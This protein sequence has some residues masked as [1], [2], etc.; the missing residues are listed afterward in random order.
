MKK[1]NWEDKLISG[2]NGN[3]VPPPPAAWDNIEAVL[4]NKDK[5][6]PLVFFLLMG[7]I[8]IGAGL[9]I[10]FN[11]F[12]S[13]KL[14]E[15]KINSNNTA[16]ADFDKKENGK[17]NEL[18]VN[19]STT[20]VGKL[21]IK[22]A[23]S[24]LNNNKKTA[25]LN[26]NNTLNYSENKPENK[27]QLKNKNQYTSAAKTI[28]N[29]TTQ[30]NSKSAVNN[31]QKTSNKSTDNINTPG[32]IHSENTQIV[33]NDNYLSTEKIEKSGEKQTVINS[34]VEV[35]TINALDNKNNQ[36]TLQDLNVLKIPSYKKVEC[37]SFN[38]KRIIPFVEL[39]IGAGIPLRKLSAN[40][41]EG[42]LFANKKATENPWYTYN[43]GLYGGLILRNNMTI[44]AGVNYSEFIEKFD[45]TLTGIT[46]IVIN[47]D[48][49]TNIPI[50]TTIKSGSFA[51]AYLNH[52]RLINIPVKIGYQKNMK[53]WILAGEV[54]AAFNLSL[55]TKG[56]MLGS[57]QK[58][59]DISDRND[60]YKNSVGLMLN[61]GIAAHYKL[62]DNLSIY[63]KPQ[64]VGSINE[65]TQSNAAVKLSYEA[66]NLNV[67][68]RKAFAGKKK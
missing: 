51:Y 48:P 3:S 50:D 19:N 4:D 60:L 41:E 17:D 59:Y 5:K 57:D 42:K 15:N 10:Y 25:T 36:L 9:F 52:L 12:N 49:V 61:V 26:S 55:N 68:I 35:K 66:L 34:A 67:G 23:E 31:K 21:E 37:Y 30:T 58:I 65:W 14:I 62:N 54:G 32:L 63:V 24:D 18:S 43:A 45:H 11:N 38:K 16:I 33:K 40:N 22:S 2:A 1:Q 44:S 64:Y 27:L 13:G 56:R 39:E 53:K 6:R 7:L 29:P 46:Q 20:S 47:V 28:A 8:T